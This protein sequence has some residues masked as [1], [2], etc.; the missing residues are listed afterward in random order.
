MHPGLGIDQL[1]HDPQLVAG[2]A[3]R[4]TP[5]YVKPQRRMRVLVFG[6]SFTA[7]DGVSNGSRYS[8]VLETLLPPPTEVHNFGLPGSGKKIWR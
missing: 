2:A 8:D 3:R 7:G 4:S 1:R 6:D 5:G